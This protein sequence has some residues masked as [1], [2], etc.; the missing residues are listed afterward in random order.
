MSSG[1]LVSVVGAS[2]YSGGEL[3]DMLANHPEFI[4]DKLY[5]SESSQWSGKPF[6]TAFPALSSVTTNFT[7]LPDV[8]TL[9]QSSS[10]V[11]FLAT[12]HELS[13]TLVP[14]L[15][16]LGKTVIDLSAAYRLNNLHDYVNYYSFEHGFMQHVETACY[17]LTE[18]FAEQVAESKLIAVPGCYPTAS[19]LAL[20]P[21]KNA[22]LLSDAK[23]VINA[24]SGVSGAG[25]PAK[26]NTSFCE[27][28]LS[29]YGIFKHR[30]QP[31][32]QQYLGQEVV[33][34]PHLGNFKRGILATIYCEL[35]PGVTQADVD[36]VFSQAYAGET[37]IRLRDT[38]PKVDEVAHTKRCDI[39]WQK[40]PE[41]Q[42]LILVSAIDNLLK[43]A[44]A[45]ALQCANLHL[46][47]E[48]NLGL[49]VCSG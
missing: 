41:D 18:Y 28:S 20:L 10:E 7:P 26:Q 13:H 45:Q 33:F 14:E 9:A 27:V 39:F 24:V 23:P 12:P 32:I 22:G 47:W 30:H 25:R 40:S 19:L 48:K 17:G 5:V 42:G 11:F 35:N 49:A 44:A 37:L 46:G 38:A 29:P 15:L 31:E 2:G 4:L 3:V 34:T 8:K 36:A 21:L 1:V 6:N 43:G 16:S